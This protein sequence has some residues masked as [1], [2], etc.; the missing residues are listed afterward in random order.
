M[1]DNILKLITESGVKL[2]TESG[3]LAQLLVLPVVCIEPAGGPLTVGEPQSE[4]C[5]AYGT[6]CGKL[7]LGT[8]K[9]HVELEQAKKCKDDLTTCKQCGGNSIFALCPRVR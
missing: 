7:N 8:P 9:T 2:I 4:A 1:G 5:V 3:V 6:T